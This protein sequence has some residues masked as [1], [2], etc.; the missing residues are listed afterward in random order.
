MAARRQGAGFR[1]KEVGRVGLLRA[2]R[3]FIFPPSFRD[4]LEDARERLRGEPLRMRCEA[5]GHE[6]PL[7][8]R[9]AN[10]G[11]PLGPPLS[12]KV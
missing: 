6:G 3:R 1:T 5:C 12:E 8:E 11:R 4:Y 7:G 9:C 2:L 10:C